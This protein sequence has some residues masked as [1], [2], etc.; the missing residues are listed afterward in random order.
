MPPFLLVLELPAVER[1]LAAET[2][3]DAMGRADGPVELR[4]VGE[5]EFVAGIAAMSASG[6]YGSTRAAAAIVGHVDLRIGARAR[7]VLEAHVAAG[8]GRFRG[9]R[10]SSVYHPDP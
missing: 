9:I 3:V 7:A 10:Q 5:T 1:H 4:P 6:G 8:G 2:A